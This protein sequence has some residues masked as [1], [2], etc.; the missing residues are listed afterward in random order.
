MTY[1][2]SISYCSCVIIRALFINLNPFLYEQNGQP[3][4]PAEQKICK[5]V[6]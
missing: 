3:L 1:N 4:N 6:V 5:K 2:C